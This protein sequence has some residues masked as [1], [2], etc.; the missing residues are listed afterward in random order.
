MEPNKNILHKTL[1]TVEKVGNGVNKA[2]IGC[3]WI[4]SNLCFMG[5]CLWAVIAGV[6][7]IKLNQSGETVTGTVIEMQESSSPDSGCCTYSPV[8]E[9]QVNGQTYTIEGGI[10]SDPPQYSVG[11]QVAIV[12]DPANPQTAQIN[13]L[14]E[15]WL[16][17]VLVIPSM[18]AAS[19]LTTFFLFR[20]WR[21]N[22]D[23]IGEF[24]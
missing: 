24:I 1:D 2:A 14:A 7:A 13:S 9:Y 18:I 8:I 16:M 5:F 21:N 6:N 22:Y 3:V 17:P 23:L 15:N 20:A 12:Y 19:A 11:D 10:A 4:V